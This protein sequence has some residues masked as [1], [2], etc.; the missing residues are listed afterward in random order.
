[1]KLPLCALLLVGCAHSHTVVITQRPHAD[2][3]T[4]KN[5][6]AHIL[7]TQIKEA[8][9]ESYP[10]VDP[11]VDESYTA[12]QALSNLQQE[13]IK[14]GTQSAFFSECIENITPDAATCMLHHDTSSSITECDK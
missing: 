14:D 1:M 4:C 11:A 7:K 12:G 5:I 6:Y 9:A 13:Y 3:A 2:Q 10:F 8:Q